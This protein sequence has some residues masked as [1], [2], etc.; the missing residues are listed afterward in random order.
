VGGTPVVGSTLTVASNGI[1]TGS[2]H[3]FGYSW[4]RCTFAGGCRAVPVGGPSYPVTAADIG[5][6]ISLVVSANS[7]SGSEFGFSTWTAVVTSGSTGGGGGTSGGGGSIPNLNVRLTASTT[8]PITDQAIDVV[9]T[10]VNAGAASAQKSHLVIDLA[11]TMTLVGTPAFESGAGCTG[12]QR[13]DCNLDY[14]PGN[15]VSTNVRF[16]V[17]VSGTGAQA[18]NATVSADRD[19]NPADNAMALVLLVGSLPAAPGPI[20][21]TVA[22]I[23]GTTRADV[24]HGSTVNDVIRGLGGNDRLFGRGGDDTLFGG[25][26]NDLL[27]GGLGR[28]KLLGGAGR[29]TLSGGSG[30]D[31]LD[32]GPGLDLFR[33]GSGNDSLKARDG[34]RE[35]VDCGAGRDTATVDR[36]DVV[37]GCEKVSRR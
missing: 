34:K 13:I 12:T 6:A 20:P 27:D 26:G 8:S 5:Y 33:A 24:L 3:A 21:P 16:V 14:I 32:G 11:P 30:N 4:R 23:T 37:R 31:M 29:D 10:V 7:D 28:D 35:I 19:S 25:L 1:W 18:I 2:P 9:A 22:Q 17:R 36:I 15:G